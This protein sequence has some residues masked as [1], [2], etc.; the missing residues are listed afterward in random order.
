MDF[1]EFIGKIINW[2]STQK[3]IILNDEKIKKYLED[4]KIIPD[5]IEL[6]LKELTPKS[7]NTT[8][9]RF[10]SSNNSGIEL[11]K[12]THLLRPGEKFAGFREL[13]SYC[14]AQKIAN[15]KGKYFICL[16]NSFYYSNFNNTYLHKFSVSSGSWADPDDDNGSNSLYVLNSQYISGIIPIIY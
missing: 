6:I 13:I 16:S 9:I 10:V 1:I 5:H 4:R 15:L 12:Y 2:F 7:K 3:I 8:R 11:L 14:A